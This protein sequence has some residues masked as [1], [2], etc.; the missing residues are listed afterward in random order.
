[1]RLVVTALVFLI[2]LFFIMLGLGFLF[3]PVSTGAVIGISAVNGQGLASL[4]GDVFAFFAIIGICMVWGAWKR[5]GDLLLVPA[6][7]MGLVIVGRLVSV[8]TDGT[9]E[10]F[11]A[12]I[13]LE[14]AI[15]AVALWARAMLPHHKLEDVGE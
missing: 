11:V 4:R 2:G 14:V 10:N 3:Q 1:M 15:A 13:I 7:M 6:I 5:K 9:Y 12:P 8:A